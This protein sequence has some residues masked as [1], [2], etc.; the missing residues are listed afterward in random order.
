[1]WILGEKYGSY[2]VANNRRSRLTEPQLFKS[3]IALSIGQISFQWIQCKY[4]GNQ[5]HYQLDRDLYGG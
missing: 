5:L 1:M 2:S 4:W 3:L